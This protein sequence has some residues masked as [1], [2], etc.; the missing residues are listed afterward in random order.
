MSVLSTIR[1][2]ELP[3]IVMRAIVR[4]RGYTSFSGCSIGRGSGAE[5]RIIVDV[6][7][8]ATIGDY[9]TFLGGP[10]PSELKVAT[11]AELAIG[12][13]CHF[14]YGVSISVRN[15]VTIGDR[16]MFGSY[17][18]IADAQENKVA[19]V[20]IGDDVWIGHGAVIAPGVTIGDGSV[21]AAG[22]VVSQD[23]P[24]RMMAMGNPARM[25]S[26]QLS[27]NSADTTS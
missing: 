20:V 27:P 17:V 5:G 13:K 12:D 14:N 2:L 26:L 24:P 21:V 9:V 7:G 23:V 10:V 11:G 15:R 22:S 8:K 18:R 19:P 25:M 16:C 6:K 4:I 3:R 1:Q